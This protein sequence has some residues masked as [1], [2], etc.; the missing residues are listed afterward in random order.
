LGLRVSRLI[1]LVLALGLMAGL[2]TLILAGM[3][4]ARPIGPSGNPV[5]DFQP[6]SQVQAAAMTYTF[7]YGGDADFC[8]SNGCTL[9]GAIN[10][11]NANPGADTIVSAAFTH[12]IIL[13]ST[14]I[15]SDDVTIDGSGGDV[16]INGNNSV[17]VMLVNSGKTL[18]L[19]AV[20][21]ANGRSS[22]FD[23]GGG[24][25]N[26]GTLNVTN[27]TF[28]SNES[29]AGGGIYN[30][31]GSTLTVTSSS[32]VSN[33]AA[34]EGGGIGNDGTLNVT[35]STFTGN[36]AGN[37]GGGIFTYRGTLDVTNSTFLSNTGSYG[38]GIV[39][40]SGMLTVTNSTFDR[41]LATGSG[42]FGGGAIYLYNGF[43]TPTVLLTNV[44]FANNDAPNVA[45]RD[46]IFLS[47]VGSLTLR[48]VLLSN[49]GTEN[50]ANTGGTL[51][52]DAF[53]MSSDA[54]CGSATQKTVGEIN[55]GPLA[56]NGGST[57]TMALPL[58]SAA[59]DAGDNTVCPAT[60]QRGV[61][62]PQGGQCDVGAF[63]VV[64][65]NLPVILK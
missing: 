53:S 1:G 64:K 4:Q 8:D 20:T 12:N 33:T 54:T 45:G 14:L 44:T 10:A 19:N 30:N 65:V 11:A 37:G 59:I 24:I 7:Y 17:Q 38:G 9:R 58:D 43:G 52:T 60:D 15:I 22:F 16:T 2:A 21:I 28:V 40:A 25:H 31:T 46:G 3:A 56:D 47:S 39:M 6:A 5:P 50:C 18:N 49:N 35:N 51:N 63:E 23:F 42:S 26:S 29:D 41:N 48:N 34:A 32:F 57:Q 61:T 13:G 27:S 62:R 36:T 55:L